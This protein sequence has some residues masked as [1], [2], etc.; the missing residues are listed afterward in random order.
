MELVKHD[1]LIK[2]FL[3]DEIVRSELANHMFND[4]SLC[5]LDRILPEEFSLMMPLKGT[6]VA[7]D[8]D[9][10][11]S[12]LS[13]KIKPDLNRALKDFCQDYSISPAIQ[14]Y[15]RTDKKNTTDNETEGYAEVGSHFACSQKTTKRKGEKKT[16]S[17]NISGKLKPLDELEKTLSRAINDIRRNHAKYDSIA[18]NKKTI[19]ETLLSYIWEYPRPKGHRASWAVKESA[20]LL[21]MLEAARHNPGLGT[22]IFSIELALKGFGVKAEDKIDACIKWSRSKSQK[23]EPFLMYSEILNLNEYDTKT[24]TDF[25]HT[26]AL[27]IIFAL[28]QK[29]DERLEQYVALMFDPEYKDGDIWIAGKGKTTS[30]VFTA[31]Y[32]IELL[33]HCI[34][35]TRILKKFPEKKL[36]DSR[37]R[38][39]KWLVNDFNNNGLWKSN[40]MKYNWDCLFATSWVL[41]RLTPL[42]IDI[43]SWRT[44]VNDALGELI[45]AAQLDAK[46]WSDSKDITQRLRVEAR[47]ASAVAVTKELLHINPAI[48]KDADS[49]LHEVNKELTGLIDDKLDLAT[50]LFLVD[51]M[52][53]PDDLY[54]LAERMTESTK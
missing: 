29:E 28:T 51:S 22:A 19:P 16:K 45:Y 50:A 46:I 49:Y 30:P 34:S 18:G 43:L 23:R 5:L 42:K 9:V 15:F 10:D 39:V 48:K 8:V 21:G 31:I 37:D 35:N 36:I 14:F 52:I 11:S 4:D 27:A 2:T 24:E 26:L 54:D 25:R 38:A 13:D 41:R 1:R 12:V 44:C 6:T 20:V 32:G 7:D 17:N 3:A 40:V 53:E 47:V 33:T